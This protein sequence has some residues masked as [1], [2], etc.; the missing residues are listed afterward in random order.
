MHEITFSSASKTLDRVREL[1]LKADRVNEAGLA[2]LPQR[3][4]PCVNRHNHDTCLLHLI[5][6]AAMLADVVE[7]PGQRL[8]QL[9]NH[10]RCKSIWVQAVLDDT[11]QYACLGQLR[12]HWRIM[13]F[14]PCTPH[15]FGHK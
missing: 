8:R 9:I 5:W 1:K 6:V 14:G 4:E 7:S 12:S 15:K 10:L 11:G 2:S 13:P 3:R